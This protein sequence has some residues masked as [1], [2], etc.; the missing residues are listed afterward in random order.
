MTDDSIDQDLD[1]FMLKK[2]PAK[3]LSVIYRH[4]KAYPDS[5]LTNKAISHKLDATYAH[6]TKTLNK[7]ESYQLL[8]RNT[9]GQK[10]ENRLTDAGAELAEIAVVLIDKIAEL[11]N[12][13]D[14]DI[15][16]K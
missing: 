13:H 7:L 6:T 2:I 9:E 16:E 14:S 15:S 3:A 4:Q 1:E 5:Y 11:E 12:I 8:D 10:V